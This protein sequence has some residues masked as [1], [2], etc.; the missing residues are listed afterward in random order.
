MPENVPNLITIF[1]ETLERTD[2]AARAAYLD[3][4]GDETNSTKV[5]GL[6]FP[7]PDP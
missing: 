4:V 3:G 7:R 5:Q 6:A 1:A 2:P